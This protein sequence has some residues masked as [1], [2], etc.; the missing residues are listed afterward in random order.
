MNTI[1]ERREGFDERCLPLFQER[2]TEVQKSKCARR[3]GEVIGS[4]VHT[5]KSP[6]RRAGEAGVDFGE[7]YPVIDHD[8]V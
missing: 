3:K 6:I 4:A 7:F 8:L 1:I 5:D 2:E